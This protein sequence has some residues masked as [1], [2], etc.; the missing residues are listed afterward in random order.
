MVR[1]KKDIACRI[2]VA[3]SG[4][5]LRRCYP[6]VAELR[7]HLSEAAFVAQ[8]RRQ[9]RAGFRLV[10]LEADGAIQSVAG[11]R[12]SENLAWGR[13]LYV[14]DLVTRA[15][16]RSQ[17][18]G[19]RLFTWLLARARAAGCDQLHLDSGVQ[20]FGAHRFYLRQGMDITSHHFAV[21]L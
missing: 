5:D 15:A 1:R 3:V 16:T 13:F 10:Y 19:R 20:R 8:V 12:L 14:D 4:K 21:R 7:P 18:W 11:Y 2:R 9:R 17:G 6:V